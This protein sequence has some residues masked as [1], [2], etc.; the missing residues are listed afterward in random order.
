[1]EIITTI[2][3]VMSIAVLSFGIHMAYEDIKSY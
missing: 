3:A 1:M 2:W